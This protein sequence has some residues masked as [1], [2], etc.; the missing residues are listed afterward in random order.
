ME[1]TVVERSREKRLVLAKSIMFISFIIVVVCIVVSIIIAVIPISEKNDSGNT[2]PLNRPG[3]GSDITREEELSLRKSFPLDKQIDFCLGPKL[4]VKFG[5]DTGGLAGS[6]TAVV[7]LASSFNKRGFLVTIYGNLYKGN[8]NGVLYRDS[9]DFDFD[10]DHGIV[11]LWRAFGA[12]GL[13][14]ALRDKLLKNR[15]YRGEDEETVRLLKEQCWNKENIR[16]KQVWLDLHDD[17][18]PHEVETFSKIV[19]RIM[20]KSHYH[21]SLY[22]Q[23]SLSVKSKI[24]VIPNGVTDISFY[25]SSRKRFGEPFHSLENTVYDSTKKTVQ[26][27]PSLSD[28]YLKNKKPHNSGIEWLNKGYGQGKHYF[29]VPEK[30]FNPNR[31][32][33]SLQRRNKFKIIYTSCYSRGLEG[34]LDY[35]WPIIKRAFPSAELHLFYGMFLTPEPIRDKLKIHVERRD[36]VFNHGRLDRDIMRRMAAD[37]HIHFYPCTAHCEVDC[38]SIKESA[39]QGIIPVIPYSFVFPERPGVLFDEYSTVG[40]EEFF[41]AGAHKVVQVM[42]EFDN[43]DLISKS[44]LDPM[45]DST[46]FSWD[47]IATLWLSHMS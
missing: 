11:I 27:K 23:C 28:G 1:E 3:N 30:P 44:Y 6:E 19:D 5:G 45:I 12:S 31:P 15:I 46:C 36:G 29:I 21:E 38:I 14:N 8:Y 10:V 9:S 13:T 4:I 35:S 39:L 20:L 47:H 16:A 24:L 40:S 33:S 7:E 17:N 22:S 34:L 32:S 26:P 25:I 18:G 42:E 37:A 41:R 2:T 43:R